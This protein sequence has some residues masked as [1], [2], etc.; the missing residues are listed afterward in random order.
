MKII[1]L[2]AAASLLLA[3]TAFAAPPASPKIHV[4]LSRV[5]VKTIEDPE[6]KFLQKLHGSNEMEISMGK[7][8]LDRASDAKV[9][10]YAN[11]LIKDHQDADDKVQARLK[12]K[13]WNLAGQPA[14]DTAAE[15]AEHQ[16]EMA[17]LKTLS[18]ADFDKA[19]LTDMIADHDKD[20]PIVA[21]FKEKESD[22]A[23]HDELQT[24]FDK[25]K[26]HREKA[27]AL[28]NPGTEIQ[29]TSG[30]D[31]T[32]TDKDKDMDHDKDATPDKDKDDQKDK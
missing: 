26:V 21:D 18:G 7:I 14:V 24:I 23:F 29:N 10:D 25:M 31:K 1:R 15:R 3:G 16:T 27:H 28:L 22:K 2:S 4:P 6:F 20:L 19:F 12:A 17:R 11:M 9:K 13:G 32:D 30:T 8:A 5:H